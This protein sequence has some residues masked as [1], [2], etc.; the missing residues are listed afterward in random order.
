MEKVFSSLR[1]IAENGSDKDNDAA[2]PSPQF[3]A[4]PK[5]L[6]PEPCLFSI[7]ENWKQGARRELLRIYNDATVPRSGGQHAPSI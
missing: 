6:L 4:G 7:A 5:T 1:Y 3:S 2:K